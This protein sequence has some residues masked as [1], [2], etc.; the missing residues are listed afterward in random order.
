ML[1]LILKGDAFLIEKL[2]SVSV[3][4]VVMTA[5]QEKCLFGI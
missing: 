1:L 4:L 3:N 5:G 2:K